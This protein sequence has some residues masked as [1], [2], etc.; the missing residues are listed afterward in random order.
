[1][2]GNNVSRYDFFNVDSI[3][4]YHSGFRMYN[5]GVWRMSHWTTSKKRNFLCVFATATETSYKMQLHC[6]IFKSEN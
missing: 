6:K 3:Y 2:A 4:E 5:F 1:M